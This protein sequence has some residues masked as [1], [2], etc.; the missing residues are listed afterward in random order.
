MVATEPPARVLDG[1]RIDVPAIVVPEHANRAKH[2]ILVPDVEDIGVAVVQKNTVLAI[3]LLLHEGEHLRQ[4]GFGF[5]LAT[6][7]V[8]D[9]A[10]HRVLPQLVVAERLFADRVFGLAVAVKET[11]FEVVA[12]VADLHRSIALGV[13]HEP[14]FGDELDGGCRDRDRRD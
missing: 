4:G 9:R 1:V 11:G 13:D 12:E 5:L 8:D 6:E 14:V 2:T 7:F 3:L 10:V